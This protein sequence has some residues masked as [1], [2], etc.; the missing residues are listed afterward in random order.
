ME[1]VESKSVVVSVSGDDTPPERKERTCSSSGRESI[2]E[3]GGVE[4]ENQSSRCLGRKEV[5]MRQ[6]W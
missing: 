3:G 5:G 1:G 6:G 4:W 2:R